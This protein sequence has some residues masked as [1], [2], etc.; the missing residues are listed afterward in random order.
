M[1]DIWILEVLCIAQTVQQFDLQHDYMAS[2]H[3]LQILCVLFIPLFLSHDQKMISECR[4]SWKICNSLTLH[5]Y[6]GMSATAN[7]RFFEFFWAIEISCKC[8]THSDDKDK[9]GSPHMENVQVLNALFSL[10]FT[11]EDQLL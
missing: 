5:L 11:M 10:F 2:V 7:S 8:T 6:V 1:Q 3:G 9:Q 4:S